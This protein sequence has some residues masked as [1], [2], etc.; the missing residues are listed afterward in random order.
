MRDA[1]GRSHGARS[2]SVTGSTCGTARIGADPDSEFQ[3]DNLYSGIAYMYF[4]LH[5]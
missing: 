5:E 4:S 1:D 3:S 2:G